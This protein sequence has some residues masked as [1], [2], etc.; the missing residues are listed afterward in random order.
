MSQR[1]FTLLEL[2]ISMA[3]GLI[4]LTTVYAALQLTVESM[5]V[6]ERLGLENRL[7]AAGVAQALE[8]TDSWEDLDQAS[9][10]FTPLR[11]P[12]SGNLKTLRNNPANGTQT[13]SADGSD[14]QTLA[15]PFSARSTIIA[16]AVGA[17]GMDATSDLLDASSWEP[18]SS[19]AW[20]RGDGGHFD[21]GGT[22]VTGTTT[23][24]AWLDESAFGNYGIFAN[25]SGGSGSQVRLGAQ[26]QASGFVSNATIDWTRRWAPRQHKALLQSFGFFGWLDYVPANA[27]LDWADVDD[28]AAAP[29]RIQRAWELRAAYD[30][31]VATLP[32]NTHVSDLGTL[33][34]SA[35]QRV[36][37]PSSLGN[38]STPVFRTGAERAVTPGW[39]CASAHVGIAGPPPGADATASRRMAGLNRYMGLG[40][41]DPNQNIFLNTFPLLLGSLGSN[42]AERQVVAVRP[43]SWPGVQV[44]LRRFRRWGSSSAWCFVRMVDP[45]NGTSVQLSFP[46][47]GTTLRGARLN[48]GL[49]Q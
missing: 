5:K 31:A 9:T 15:Q 13:Y 8:R 1:A 22:L 42:G 10:G 26:N 29:R 25:A 4:I 38:W 33:G 12:V 20:Y 21:H 28:S 35:R 32:S 43:A 23:P 3:L 16:Q 36:E 17:W 14:W 27:V 7:L 19:A 24:A 41:Q 48:R 45:I 30:G 2:M 11:T 34:R 49:D 47:V 37:N 39:F 44:G 18:S 40:M 46:A 6:A